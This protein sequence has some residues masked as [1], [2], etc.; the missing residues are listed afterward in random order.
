MMF[1][2][3]NRFYI[4]CVYSRIV[5]LKVPV[6]R[7]RDAGLPVCSERESMMQGE[8]CMLHPLTLA[9]AAFSAL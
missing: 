8:G 2:R 4:A 3:P 9:V 5:L 6:E 1:V 7:Q